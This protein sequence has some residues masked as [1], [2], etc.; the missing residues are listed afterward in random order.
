MG[1]INKTTNQCELSSEVAIRLLNSANACPED[2]TGAA[3][4]PGPS[5]DDEM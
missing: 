5:Y 3:V 1:D 2:T 4:T